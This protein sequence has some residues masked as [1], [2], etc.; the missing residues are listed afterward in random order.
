VICEIITPSAAGGVIRWAL[1]DDSFGL[2]S[3]RIWDLGTVPA[4]VAGWIDLDLSGS[5]KAVTKGT[6]YHIVGASQVQ[7]ATLTASTNPFYPSQNVP[8]GGYSFPLTTNCH[9][10]MAGAA[11]TPT[12]PKTL[13]QTMYSVVIL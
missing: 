13:I 12:P 5:P 11:P 4:D 2:P 9:F 8:G 7:V 3:T 1:Y 6:L 10:S